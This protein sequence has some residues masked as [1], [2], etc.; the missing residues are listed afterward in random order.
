MQIKHRKLTAEKKHFDGLWLKHW[1]D[2]MRWEN[3]AEK[4]QN[5]LAIKTYELL[6]QQKR[7]LELEK[8]VKG[9][10]AHFNEIFS[11]VWD[12]PNVLDA[13]AALWM[14]WWR[15]RSRNSWTVHWNWKSVY[16]VW[17]RI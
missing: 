8:R 3:I 15:W 17:P 9:L 13:G 7:A 12:A 5:E 11:D 6:V 1:G 14:I 2:S 10:A 4:R 16:K